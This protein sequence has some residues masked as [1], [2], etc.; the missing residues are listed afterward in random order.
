[1]EIA[2]NLEL[3]LKVQRSRY[4]SSIYSL[5]SKETTVYLDLLQAHPNH[6]TGVYLPD[7]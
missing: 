2:H 4:K 6:F 1:M 5:G 7:F 3:T